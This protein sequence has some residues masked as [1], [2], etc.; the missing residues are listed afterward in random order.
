[1]AKVYDLDK[2]YLGGD[3]NDIGL[4]GLQFAAADPAKQIAAPHF[5]ILHQPL[6]TLSTNRAGLPRCTAFFALYSCGLFQ[7]KKAALTMNAAF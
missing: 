5:F 4:Q 2:G 7:K 6:N 3:N 1:M